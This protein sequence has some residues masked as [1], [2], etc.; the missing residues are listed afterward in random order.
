MGENVDAMPRDDD[1]PDFLLFLGIFRLL[2]SLLCCLIECT[3]AVDRTKF[4]L[5]CFLA[6][7]NYGKFVFF[8]IFFHAQ[9]KFRCSIDFFPQE[10]VV[11][12][13]KV[14][15]F[16]AL[17]SNLESLNT[18]LWLFEHS[19]AED[20]WWFSVFETICMF[21][22]ANGFYIKFSVRN[23][24]RPRRKFHNDGRLGLDARGFDSWPE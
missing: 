15:F 17:H 7:N 10:I 20:R 11:V 21:D 5:I 19:I 23:S 12:L 18:S 6:F 4:K 24:T 3:V 8:W 16:V 1:L 22:N 14:N 2:S 13:R 9:Q